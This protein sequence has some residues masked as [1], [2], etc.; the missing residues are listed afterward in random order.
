M[1]A[2]L[3][4]SGALSPFHDYGDLA[5]ECV[6][7]CSQFGEGSTGTGAAHAMHCSFGTSNDSS[8]QLLWAT[9]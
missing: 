5:K 1:E 4:K 8:M 2:L 6:Q 9:A 7:F 3:G